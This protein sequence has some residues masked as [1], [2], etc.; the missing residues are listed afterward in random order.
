MGIHKKIKEYIEQWEKRCYSNGIPD[1][2]PIQIKDKVPSYKKICL[3]I[4]KNDFKDLGY[5]P[6]KSKY[7]SLLKRIEINQRIYK[8]KQ[9]KLNI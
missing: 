3:S 4:L 2:A 9:L 1:E 5:Y 7:Y 6:K 8:G